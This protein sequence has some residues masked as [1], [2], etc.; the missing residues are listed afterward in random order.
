MDNNPKHQ[1]DHIENYFEVNWWPPENPDLNR[2]ENLK[3]CL[4]KTKQKKKS[5][6]DISTSPRKVF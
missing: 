6:Q 2:T 1:S 5:K 4:R 3:Q